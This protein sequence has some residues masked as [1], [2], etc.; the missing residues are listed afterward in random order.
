[1]TNYLLDYVKFISELIDK[2]LLLRK[3]R[4]KILIWLDLRHS[5]SVERLGFIPNIDRSEIKI[6]VLFERRHRLAQRTPYLN[7]M[8]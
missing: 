8:I 3:L 4:N 2:E 1:M 7:K 6:V 5:N